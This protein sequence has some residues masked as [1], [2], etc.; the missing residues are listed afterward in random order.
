M[1][2]NELKKS[3]ELYRR[4]IELVMDMVVYKSIHCACLLI[5]LHWL[6]GERLLVVTFP[7]KQRKCPKTKQN[8]LSIP[9]PGK[10]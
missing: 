7:T 4:N 5:V 3:A 9:F 8:V 2:C 6:I 1:Y 10:L